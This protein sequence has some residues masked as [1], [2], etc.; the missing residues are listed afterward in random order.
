MKRIIVFM[1]CIGLLLSGCGATPA[2]TE[3][4]ISKME[5]VPSETTES[6]EDVSTVDSSTVSTEVSNKAAISE[7]VVFNN[8]DFKLTAKEIDFSDEYYVKVKFLAENN[9]DANIIFNGDIFSVNGITM[10][11]SFFIKVS[12]GKKA[13]DYLEIDKDDL[14][15]Y[16]ITNIATIKAQD[17]Y[18]YNDDTSTVITNFRFDLHTSIP[19]EYVQTIDR[20]GHTVYDQNGIIVKYRGIV[21]GHF[22]GEELEFFVENNTE[23]NLSIHVDNVSVNGFMVYGSMVAYAYPGCVTYETVY[24]SSSDLEENDIETI[25]EVSLSLY[26][27]DQ[28][29]NKML[30]ESD[31]FTVG[32]ND[33]ITVS[34]SEVSPTEAKTNTYSMEDVVAVIESSLKEN[35]DSVSI[36]YDGTTIDINISYTGLASAAQNV[37]SSNDKK[38]LESWNSFVSSLKKINSAALSIAKDAGFTDATIIMNL[39]NDLNPDNILIMI[40]N[41]ILIYDVVNS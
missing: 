36:T 40:M 23:S 38:Q 2:E 12:A 9:S 21:P 10:H 14:A 26:A 17:A 32:R 39:R 20:S 25:E 7:T 11:C 28:D 19:E 33:I 22:S 30:W 37:K 5:I 13:N 3:P 16:G 24:F 41:D 18:I 34:D 29:A 1:I 6:F 31:E 4:A 35:Y 27:Y 15:S 8:G